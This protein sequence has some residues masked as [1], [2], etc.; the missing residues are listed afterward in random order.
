MPISEEQQRPLIY[1]DHNILDLLIDVKN[2]W[3]VDFFLKLG[4]AFYSEETL[5]EIHRSGEGAKEFLEVLVKL[6]A[7]YI[8]V[9][10]N[11]RG[12]VIDNN[13]TLRDVDVYVTFEEFP[14]RV[15]SSD[16]PENRIQDMLFKMFGGL[17]DR[18]FGELASEQ[19]DCI[20][21]TSTDLVT[22]PNLAQL[23]PR[24]QLEE[25]F[26]ALDI[27]RTETA[28]IFSEHEGKMD[29]SQLRDEI[30]LGPKQL[31]NIKGPNVIMQIYDLAM[32]RA[33]KLGYEENTT[34]DQFLSISEDS[35]NKDRELLPSDKVRRIYMFLNMIG[36][37]PDS[38]MKKERRFIA[39]NSDMEHACIA[40]F[41]DI[42]ISRDYS[43]VRKCAAIYEYL[44]LP[45]TNIMHV[46]AGETG[47]KIDLYSSGDSYVPRSLSDKN[48]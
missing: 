44:E 10:T 39:A 1:L 28:D 16:S 13:A 29:V 34:V 46:E 42:L 37:N 38:K 6:N 9:A 40:I 17:P 32:E 11:E 15:R 21:D 27:Y 36:F 41:A 24:E 18:S 7:R 47:L 5:S 45:R 35:L 30:G 48:G 14:G 25:L 26:S 31:N 43:F 3:F 33:K 4:D 8:S 19:M 23:V 12:E 20:K 2:D 22:D